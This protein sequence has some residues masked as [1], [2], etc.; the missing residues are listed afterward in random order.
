VKL[1]LIL[2]QMEAFQSFHS[3]KQAQTTMSPNRGRL[4]PIRDAEDRRD[5][6][7]SPTSKA[8]AARSSPG[9]AFPAAED[10]GKSGS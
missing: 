2:R 8:S 6:L 4:D 1:S 5:Q 3:R 9:Q 7:E 10:G